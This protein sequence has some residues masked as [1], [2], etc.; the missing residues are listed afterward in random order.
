M[1][2]ET[3]WAVKVLGWYPVAA[4]SG[5]VLEAAKTAAF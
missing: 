2:K 1:G 3:V 5:R 4:G